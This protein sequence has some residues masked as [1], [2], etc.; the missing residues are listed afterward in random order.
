MEHDLTGR[1]AV[2]I[3]GG[4]SAGDGIGNGRGIC[5]NLARHGATVV[6]VARHQDRAQKTIDIIKEDCGMDGWAYAADATDRELMKKLFADVNEKYGHIDIMV[7]NAGVTLRFDPQTNT[8]TLEDV[9]RLFDVDMVGYV[10]A[11]LECAPYM[12][13][14]EK[15]GSIVCISSIA[16]KQ[17]GTGINI[18]YG[19]YAMSKSGMNKWS[20][21]AARYYAPKG[22]RVN[23]VVL[24][25][26]AS[27][28]G[29]DG[30]K[31]NEGTGMTDEMAKTIHDMSVPLKGGRQSTW[32]TSNAVV[33]LVSDEAKF[34]TG[35]EF[36]LDGGATINRGPDPDLLQMRIAKLMSEK[37]S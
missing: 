34:V 4:Q 20:E 24:G 33:F 25:S 29:T 22:I 2:V 1:V 18:G 21:L 17:N 6:A 7:Y 15:G 8:A 23:T 30:I 5:M 10:W 27:T 28:M 19:L 37:K 26:V 32:E 16:S 36:V 31:N 11:T 35:L 12:E 3:G 13:K 9:N 14:Q